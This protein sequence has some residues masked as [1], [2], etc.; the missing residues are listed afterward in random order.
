LPDDDVPQYTAVFVGSDGRIWLR[1]WPP[2][3]ELER[4]DFAVLDTA[5]T[6]EA[7]VTIPVEFS[8][9]VPPFFGG[10]VIIGVHT[11]PRTGVQSVVSAVL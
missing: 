11:D 2:V 9:D 7:F 10:S 6:L 4:T 3:G 5:G 1:L 8:T